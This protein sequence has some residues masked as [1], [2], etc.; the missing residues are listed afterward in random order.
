MF[1]SERLFLSLRPVSRGKREAP[2]EGME[3]RA[4]NPGRNNGVKKSQDVEWEWKSSVGAGG[5]AGA[6]HG[7]R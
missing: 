4:G 3:M 2:E 1:C 7:E 6:L 5:G